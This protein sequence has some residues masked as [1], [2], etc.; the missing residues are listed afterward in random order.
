MNYKKHDFYLRR[1]IL[2]TETIKVRIK[3][4]IWENK[5]LPWKKIENFDLKI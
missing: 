3:K 2:F 4:I 1:I 5:I